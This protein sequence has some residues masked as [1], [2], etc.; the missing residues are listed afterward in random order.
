MPGWKKFG[1]KYVGG[2]LLLPYDPS[3]LTEDQTS[4]PEVRDNREHKTTLRELLDSVIGVLPSIMPQVRSFLFIVYPVTDMQWLRSSAHST[5]SFQLYSILNS[6][7]MA[8]NPMLDVGIYPVFYPTREIVPY[9]IQRFTDLQAK[10]LLDLIAVDDPA[11]VQFIERVSLDGPVAIFLFLPKGEKWRENVS[12]NVED[13]LDQPVYEDAKKLFNT[14]SCI[15]SDSHMT[16]F[17]SN[18]IL[19]LFQEHCSRKPYIIDAFRYLGRN[20]IAGLNQPDDL[21]SIELLDSTLFAGTFDHLH[22]GHKLLL[23]TVSLMS[24]ARMTIG[25]VSD[26]GN[27]LD[28]KIDL[29]FMAPFDYRVL[30]VLQFV[31]RSIIDYTGVS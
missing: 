14:L 5:F 6:S 2:C 3:L 26:N 7:I 15:R 9:S 28:N 25:I 29:Q 19:H 21:T 10:A 23:W 27:L 1:P 8:D 4:I 30:V 24:R 13:F 12:L 20:P 11:T 31:Q 18:S 17:F 22:L 16:S